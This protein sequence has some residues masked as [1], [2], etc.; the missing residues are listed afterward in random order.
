PAVMNSILERRPWL[1]H[2]FADGGHAQPKPRG[3][4]QKVGK[5][6]LEIIKRPDEAKG[7]EVLPRRWAVER[8]HARSQHNCRP[9]TL[10]VR[11]AA[12]PMTIHARLLR[13]L[14]VHIRS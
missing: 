5:F 4:L 13:T 3:A 14:T 8:T 1:R 12:S 10:S 11:L 9:I 6:T 2:V 7:F